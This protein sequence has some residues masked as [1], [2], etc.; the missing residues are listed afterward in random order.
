MVA[1]VQEMRKPT[2]D[3]Q[4]KIDEEAS[5]RANNARAAAQ[6]AHA[7][8]SQEKRMQESCPHSLPN[9]KTSFRA[10]VN[11]DGCYRAFCPRCRFISR[12]IR[13]AEHYRN[14]EPLD[15]H[16]LDASTLTIGKLNQMADASLPPLPIQTIPVGMEADFSAA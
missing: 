7:Q 8:E 9:G 1:L 12:P 2:P 6:A 14:G 15:F 16:K 5:R 3:E 10:Q 13:A 11:S 4:R